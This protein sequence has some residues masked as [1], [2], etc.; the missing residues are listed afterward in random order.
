[1]LLWLLGVPGLGPHVALGRCLCPGLGDTLQVEARD[2]HVSLPVLRGCQ[3]SAGTQLG[4]DNRPEVLQG[5]LGRSIRASQL[6]HLGEVCDAWGHTWC[7][8]CRCAHQRQGP[9]LTWG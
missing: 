1:M 9:C 2:L 8:R 6:L 7:C 3:A 4:E 5:I